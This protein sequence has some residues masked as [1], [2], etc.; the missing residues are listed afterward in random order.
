MGYGAVLQLHVQHPDS[1]E[2][3]AIPG[4]A[5]HFSVGLVVWDLV[6]NDSVFAH[7]PILS[8]FNQP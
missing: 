2:I 4:S 1:L 3:A 6:S 7:V 8:V 5:S